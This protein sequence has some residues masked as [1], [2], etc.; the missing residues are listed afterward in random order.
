[1]GMKFKTKIDRFG[2]IVIPKR[3]RD[4]FGITDNSEIESILKM[5]FFLN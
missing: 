4:E 3:I 2:R 1:M 5:E